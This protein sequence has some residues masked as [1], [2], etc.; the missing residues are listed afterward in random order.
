M[1]SFE[2]HRWCIIKNRKSVVFS[3]LILSSIF[4]PSPT[5]SQITLFLCMHF[6]QW[7]VWV[8]GCS[9]HTACF[10]LGFWFVAVGTSGSFRCQR[11]FVFPTFPV[12][13]VST[14]SY[15]FNC[16]TSSLLSVYLDVC[17]S[18]IE[19]NKEGREHIIVLLTSAV[20][21]WSLELHKVI[22]FHGFVASLNR[23]SV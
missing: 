14:W 11:A 8:E 20:L 2:R 23:C 16:R 3:F 19:A 1:M 6:Q 13:V 5:A 22:I 17:L 10:L 21:T 15:T 12:S 4:T 7:K 18:R 9:E